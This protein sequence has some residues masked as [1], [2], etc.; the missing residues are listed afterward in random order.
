MRKHTRTQAGGHGQQTALHT[1][2]ALLCN[3]PLQLKHLRLKTALNLRQHLLILRRRDERHSHSVRSEATRATHSVEIVVAVCRE[4]V[5]DDH[6]HLLHVDAAT[7]Q[8]RR[9][10]DA[11]LRL[12]E[13]QVVAHSLLHGH[14]GGERDGGEAPGGHQLLQHLGTLVVGHVDHHLVEL[15]VVQDLREAAVLRALRITPLP[16]SHLVA[17]Q[18]ELLQSVERELLVVDLHAQRLR[19][20]REGHTHVLHVLQT[21]RLGLGRQRGGEHHHLLVEGRVAEHFLDVAATVCA[22]ACPHRPT[23]RLQLLVAL[24]HDEVLQFAHVK[25]LLANEVSHASRRTDEDVA[26]SLQVLDVLLQRHASE[27]G[28]YHQIGKVLSQ[29]VELL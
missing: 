28:L 16:E 21:H 27:D 25:R 18:N 4:V 12:L 20:T 23:Q 15:V 8:L 11:Y 2:H 6:V 10:H 13:L 19:I 24:V 1:S 7:Q 26:A 14:V 3:L 29:T 5:V 9:D 22:S 17:A